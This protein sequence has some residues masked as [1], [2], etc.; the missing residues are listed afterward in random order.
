MTTF[1]ELSQIANA[2]VKAQAIKLVNAR[3]IQKLSEGLTRGVPR[4]D[5]YYYE[6]HLEGV[7]ELERL[8]VKYE[9]R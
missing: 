4:G 5:I 3:Y 6:M 7:L 2:R 9:Y 1:D 8:G